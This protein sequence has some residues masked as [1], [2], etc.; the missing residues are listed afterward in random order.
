[1]RAYIT[2][3]SA[4]SRALGV[5]AALL[6]LAAV[7]SITHMVFVRY[8]LNQSTIWQTE[9]TT[10]AIVGATFIGAPWVLI[11]RGHVNVDVLLVTMNRRVRLV[12][13]V[14]NGLCS[15][16][17]VGLLGYGAWFY[18]HEAVSFGWRT[19]SVW[20]I[21]LWIP[22]LPMLVGLAVLVLQYFA[23]IMRLILDGVPVPQDERTELFDATVQE[24]R[25]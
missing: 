5:F 3:I 25:R 16:V 20:S 9:F 19:E 1:M 18:M 22:T 13:E 4:I 2:I 7:L 8:V 15:V 17:F 24:A 14:L 6:L 12:M 11:V 23:E 10:F 21:P